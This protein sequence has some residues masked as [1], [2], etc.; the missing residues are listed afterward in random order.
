MIAS[1]FQHCLTFCLKAYVC[2]YAV[3]FVIYE[4]SF[5]FEILISLNNNVISRNL[6]HSMKDSKVLMQKKLNS[7][8]VK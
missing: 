5:A 4:G 7:E 2:A 3:D 1:P 8:V 6:L